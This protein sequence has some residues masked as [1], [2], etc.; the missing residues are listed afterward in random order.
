M[1]FKD[2]IALLKKDRARSVYSRWRYF[3]DPIMMEIAFFRLSY[4][5][6][7]VVRIPARFALKLFSYFLGIQLTPGT[8][9]GGA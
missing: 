4:G 7:L 9:L 1:S 8:K 2:S 5:T 3:Y 6:P